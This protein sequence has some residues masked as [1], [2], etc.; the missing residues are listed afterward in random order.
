MKVL[1]IKVTTF[2]SSAS[3]FVDVGF[4]WGFCFARDKKRVD[5]L[6]KTSDVM[7]EN[8]IKHTIKKSPLQSGFLL[9][10]EISL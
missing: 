6:Y 4:V 10:K 5:S 1:A 7:N 3:F 2:C 9:V 8:P